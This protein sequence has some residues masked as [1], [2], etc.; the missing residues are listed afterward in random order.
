MREHQ[1]TRH[2]K[3]RPQGR[4]LSP[5]ARIIVFVPLALLLFA[6]ART[7]DVRLWHAAQSLAIQAHTDSSKPISFTEVQASGP[8]FSRSWY[9]ETPP[10]TA[11]SDMQALAWRDSPWAGNMHESTPKTSPTFLPPPFTLPPH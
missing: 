1:A 9:V 10:S 3:P 7:W 6:Y 4:R 5:L 8:T 2:S 11:M